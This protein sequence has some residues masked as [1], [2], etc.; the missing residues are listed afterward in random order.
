MIARR[1]DGCEPRTAAALAAPGQIGEARLI[2]Y[3]DEASD[4]IPIDPGRA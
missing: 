1:T 4:G 3:D 2:N